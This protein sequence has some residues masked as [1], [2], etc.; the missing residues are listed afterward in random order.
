MVPA[1]REGA[2]WQKYRKNNPR[3]QGKNRKNWGPAAQNG[4]NAPDKERTPPVGRYERKGK[5]ISSGRQNRVRECLISGM[6][7]ISK[8]LRGNW[9]MTNKRLEKTNNKIYIRYI[10]QDIIGSKI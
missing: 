6:S 4:L 7:W 5:V 2:R 10:K 3:R 8:T 9:V 1:G